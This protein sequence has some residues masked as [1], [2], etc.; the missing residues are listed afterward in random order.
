MA[1]F[2]AG[3]AIFITAAFGIPLLFH[4]VW[5]VLL[6]YA[7]AALVLGMALSVVFQL[8][9]CVEQAEFPLPRPDTGRIENAW[10]I[11]QAE[12]AVDF[13]RRS[14]VAAWLLGGLNFQIE[15]HLFPRIC[16]INYAA[17]SKLVE[18]TCREFGV[19]YTE[20]P[21]LRAGLASHFRWL[22]RMGM[23]STN[24]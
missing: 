15:H 3:K 1:I 6:L 14:S 18:E 22:Q 4:H 5:V 20:H 24:G 13:A 16:H 7:V 21:S 17:M 19:K 10:A 8:A 23:P 2:L 12:T 9:H 11:H